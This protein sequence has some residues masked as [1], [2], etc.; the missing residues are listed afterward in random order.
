M[1]AFSNRVL[2]KDIDMCFFIFSSS[3]DQESDSLVANLDM[4]IPSLSLSRGS[5]CASVHGLV[6]FTNS[7]PFIACNPSTR[8]IM[9]WSTNILELR[10]C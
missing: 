2:A 1:I 8:K 3:H 9:Y 7:G 6:G 4:A 10:S 5:N